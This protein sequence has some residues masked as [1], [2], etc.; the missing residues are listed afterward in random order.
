MALEK[1]REAYEAEIRKDEREKT[2]RRLMGAMHGFP[3]SLPPKK[4]QKC[5]ETNNYKP[6]IKAVT[7][8]TTP[9]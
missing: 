4:V 7:P 9:S 1:I 8:P 2:V 6:I 5:I 3:Q